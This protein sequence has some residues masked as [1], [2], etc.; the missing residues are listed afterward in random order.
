MTILLAKLEK[1]YEKL[2]IKVDSATTSADIMKLWTESNDVNREHLQKVQ[3]T[4]HDI[5]TEHR[6]RDLFR[7]LI[8]YSNK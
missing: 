3:T 6:C 7:K 8:D 5:V 1:E 4:I 2:S